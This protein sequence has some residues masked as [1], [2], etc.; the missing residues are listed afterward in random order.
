MSKR[1]AETD[2]TWD[3]APSRGNVHEA[4][5]RRAARLEAE[6]TLYG[7]LIAVPAPAPAPVE[8][9]SSLSADS[10]RKVPPSAFPKTK[11]ITLAEIKLPPYNKL[12]CYVKPKAREDIRI[13][14][15][16]LN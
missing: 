16:W 14:D 13:E 12:E 8:Y 1:T 4:E 11:S 3:N 2:A 9:L 15:V 7:P 5:R 10:L 6:D